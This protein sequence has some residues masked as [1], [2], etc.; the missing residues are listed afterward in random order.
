MIAEPVLRVIRE[1]NPNIEEKAAATH[2]L[3]L[4]LF[5]QSEGNPADPKGKA[6]LNEAMQFFTEMV[7]TYKD[8][9][10]NGFKLSEQAAAML[11]EIE[12]LNPGKTAP[13]IEGK[14]STGASFK[15]SEY[16]GKIV[17]LIFWGS[18]CH[19]C[20]ATLEGVKAAV[21]AHADQAV[22]LGVNTDP[23]ETY[24]QLAAAENISWRNWCDEFNRGPIS[25]VWNIRHWPTIYV[26]DSKGVICG[27]DVPAGLLDKVISEVI[28]AP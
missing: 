24:K 28:A 14:D 1:K 22:L 2:G 26:I 21:Q 8:V 18:W 10:C 12:N 17:V 7:T 11:F 15:L 16:R 27:K 3:G 5:A 4:C 20:H 9:V 13:E 6:A 25:A 19:A 23:L